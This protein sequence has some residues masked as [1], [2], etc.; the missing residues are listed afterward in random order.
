MRR[1][2]RGAGARAHAASAAAP[3]HRGA[4]RPCAQRRAPPPRVGGRRAACWTGE[5]ELREGSGGTCSPTSCGTARRTGS[6]SR[7]TSTPASAS[8]ARCTTPRRPAFAARRCSDRAS[9]PWLAPAHDGTYEDWYLLDDF[10]APRG[11][12]RGGGRA[13]PPQL[14]RRASPGASARA[15]AGC[16]GCWR[17]TPI[18]RA[19]PAGRCGSPARRA[20]RAASSP[21]ARGWHRSRARKPLAPRAGIR[22]GARVLPALARATAGRLPDTPAAGWRAQTI[23]RKRIAQYG[24]EPQRGSAGEQRQQ[25]R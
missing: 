8:T 5:P 1:L 18:S 10:A 25:R 16:T 17:A 7:P 6:S 14:P 12:Q 19:A 13:R 9:A 15:P 20:S 2:P 3:D 22:P 23:E 24:P 21:A 11:A 4:H